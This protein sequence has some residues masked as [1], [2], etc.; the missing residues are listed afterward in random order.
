[1]GAIMDQVT[2]F[3][4]RIPAAWVEPVD[5]LIRRLRLEPEVLDEV[6]RL[7]LGG[8]SGESLSADRLLE[9]DERL[10]RVEAHMA[11]QT[12]RKKEGKTARIPDRQRKASGFWST[13]DSS[14]RKSPR[15]SAVRPSRSRTF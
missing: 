15:G 9:I 7:A 11:G 13:Q 6:R 4:R 1:M 12:E 3:N 2:Q 5:R 14:R 8:G 10:S